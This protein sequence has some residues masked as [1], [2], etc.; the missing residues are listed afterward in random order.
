ML[1]L[2]GTGKIIHTRLATF[3]DKEWLEVTIAYEDPKQ[4]KLRVV[5][6]NSNG[7][8]TAVKSG[9]DLVNTWVVFHGDLAINRVRS[10]YTEDGV[11]KTLKCP[12]IRLNYAYLE[13]MPVTK[14]ATPVDQLVAA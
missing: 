13:R 6:T 3:D 12:E 2:N 1:K 7:L 5:V 11:N 10:H 14:V 4:N 8:L 9:E